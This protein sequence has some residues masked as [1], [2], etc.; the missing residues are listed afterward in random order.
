MKAISLK[1]ASIAAVVVILAAGGA[2]AQGQ[3]AAGQQASAQDSS[4]QAAAQGPSDVNVVNLPTVT[5]GNTA[6]QP[7]PVKEPL[8]QAVN[9]NFS[10]AMAPGS[11]SSDRGTFDIPA[12][13][14]L[15]IEHFAAECLSSQPLELIVELSTLSVNLSFLSTK[16]MPLSSGESLSVGAGPVRA[17][18][19][20]TA[21]VAVQV[22]RDTL[23][24]TTG[25][26]VTV[27]GYLTPLQ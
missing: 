1:S 11:R 17:Y 9:L 12:G 23:E 20:D 24:G 18:L 21:T 16:S 6:L 27:L 15:V 7:I 13:K 3:R 22:V 19:D 26:R 5:V 14:R 10:L 4:P 25:C 8:N 2:A